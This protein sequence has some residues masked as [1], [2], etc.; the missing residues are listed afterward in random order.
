MY[1]LVL[2]ESKR[3][4]VAKEMKSAGWVKQTMFALLWPQQQRSMQR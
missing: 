3:T 2:D 1:S 4:E